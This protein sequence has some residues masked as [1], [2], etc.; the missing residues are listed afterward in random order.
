MQRDMR[1][2][3]AM[4]TVDDL[5]ELEQ[6]AGGFLGIHIHLHR[7]CVGAVL[8]GAFGGGLGAVQFGPW[9]AAGGGLAGGVLAGMAGC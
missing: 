6:V 5:A 9:A 8:G 2:T 7:R 3:P 4:T 1:Q